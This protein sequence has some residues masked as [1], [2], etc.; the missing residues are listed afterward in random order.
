MQHARQSKQLDPLSIRIFGSITM[1]IN[2]FRPVT[3]QSRR[4]LKVGWLQ[5]G[6]LSKPAHQL[7]FHSVHFH[8]VGANTI[9]G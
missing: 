2:L 8:S 9:A 3:A 6:A 7:A 5:A 4:I 1:V